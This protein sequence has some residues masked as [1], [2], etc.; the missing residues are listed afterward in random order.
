MP[1]TNVNEPRCT[2]DRL[3]VMSANSSVASCV[4]RLQTTGY[5][6]VVGGVGLLCPE[7][8]PIPYSIAQVRLQTVDSRGR[9]LVFADAVMLVSVTASTQ[10]VAKINN[11]SI[12]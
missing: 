8:H 7:Q 12:L 3:V 1:S 5:V 11:C 9:S 4:H 2:V 10:G 6:N